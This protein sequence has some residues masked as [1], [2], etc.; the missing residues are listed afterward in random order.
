M[1]TGPGMKL[2]V[3]NPYVGPRPFTR[4]EA[5]LF[6]GRD[7]EARDLLSLVVSE[8]LVL[9][10]AQSGAGK[11]SLV[12]TRLVPGLE[13]RDFEVLP[14][15]RV[16]GD[17]LS[18]DQCDNIFTFNLFSHLEQSKTVPDEQ[19]KTA[20]DEQSKAALERF[21]RMRLADFLANL[22][23]DGQHF[24]YAEPSD[25]P[26]S[27]GLQAD[28]DTTTIR[29][30]VLIIDQFEE[31]VTTHP[32]AWEKRAD[33]FTQIAEAMEQDPYLW[34]V[35]V[36]RED[37]VATFD[38]FAH[39]L[40]NQLRA[41][42][43]MRRM[44][45]T[46]ALDA[47]RKPVEN[48]RPFDAGIAETLVDN[49]RIVT[50]SQ[51]QDGFLK[52]VYGEFV[53][54]VQLQVVC[55][56][57]WS[58][59]MQESDTLAPGKRITQK[60]I[61]AL[62]KGENLAQFINKAL[63]DFYEQAVAKV[64][65]KLPGVV[66][67]RELRS[68]FSSQVITE[69][70]TRGFVYQGKTHTEGLPNEIVN[71]LASYYIIRPETRP[72]GTWFELV[73]DRFVGPILQSNRTWLA[74]NQSRLLTDAKKWDEAARPAEMLYE[75][76]QLDAA[77]HEIQEKG[78]V[79]TELE[80]QFV[81]AAGLMFKRKR[82]FRLRLITLGIVTMFAVLS[83]LS[84]WALSGQHEAVMA[85][86]TAQ[87]ASTAAEQARAIVIGQNATA[88]IQNTA[89]VQRASTAQAAS[90][91]AEQARATVIGQNATAEFQ[92]TALMQQANNQ[93][94]S[95]SRM[96]TQIAVLLN[97]SSSSSVPATPLPGDPATP[98]FEI[99]PN[100]EQT[101]VTPPTPTVEVAERKVVIGQSVN[102][103]DISVYQFG[104]G[105]RHIIFVGGLHAGYSPS[106][107]KIAQRM[108]DYLHLNLLTI[109]PA[110]TVDVILN[111]N[112]DSLTNV[113]RSS[114]V[115]AR[116][117]ANSVELNANWDCNWTKETT[118]SPS[119][120]VV[121][122]GSAP[123]SE[124]ETVVL[125][126]YILYGRSVY[127]VYSVAVVVWEAHSV[128]GRKVGAG[129]CGERSLFSQPLA[130]VF[131]HAANYRSVDFIP[132]YQAGGM[133]DWLDSQGIPSI[134]VYLPDLTDSTKSDINAQVQ[135]LDA[136]IQGILK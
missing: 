18:H 61:D 28:I 43:Y 95:I 79:I 116:F 20:S 120:I 64:L 70:E 37:Y 1:G 49:L 6:Y 132:Y 92:N 2:P 32:E 100:P 36:M 83:G 13:E 135:G 90:T 50:E 115:K 110:V 86:N 101:Q 131:S 35:L 124:P 23:F 104:N 85:L 66:T 106:T 80:K 122:G 94:D 26:P 109:S 38:P 40:P 73:H 68:W 56:Q 44:E 15:G 47:V 19:S 65:E 29:P 51:V 128:D 72:G 33:F 87:A 12:N 121:D 4:V 97:N 17:I 46:A 96:Q 123:F 111:A 98:T 118:W 53:E 130:D 74:L 114:E 59:L 25:Q 119:N 22:A 103:Q 60:D 69:A 52:P 89:L 10:Y 7:S 117:N 5:P 126:N 62:A 107:V 105:P 48:L 99:S 133:I 45:S 16:S 77:E 81:A 57:L 88:Q 67:E 39:L 91:S 41:R 112:P 78:S 42:F 27:V 34:V 93:V 63:R 11:S 54:P 71:L 113:D 55:Y 76:N 75:G 3:V 58:S 8:Q 84:W 30:R 24:L 14:T 108:I 129:G 134:S 21:A 82:D 9:F 31:L 102:G 127:S 136:I 125:R